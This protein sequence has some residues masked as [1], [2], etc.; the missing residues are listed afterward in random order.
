MSL[1]EN[2]FTV[3]PKA[4]IRPNKIVF[5]NQILK[6]N[7]PTIK[8]KINIASDVKKDLQAM[9]VPV[10]IMPT[11][12]VHSFDLSI[13]AKA[14]I[15]QKV[16]WLYSLAKTNSV[17]NQNGKTLH[18]FKMN[19]IT[20]TLPAIQEHETSVITG[21]CLNQFL[22]E[23]KTRFNLQNYVWR[24]EFQKNGNAH[25]HIATDCYMDYHKARTIW[26]RCLGKLG[27][28]EKYAAQF[29]GM[30]LQQ[31]SDKFN[32][33]RDIE[34]NVLKSRFTYGQASRWQNPNTVDVKSVGNAKQIA[35][36]ISKYITKD[37]DIKNNKIVSDREPAS[38][39]LRLWFCSRS[40]SRL[41]KIEYFLE[42]V[43]EL[44]DKALAG[45]QAV[46]QYFY[47]YVKV[48][49]FELKEQTFET[50]ASLWLLYNNYAR[51][52]GYVAWRPL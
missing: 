37:S 14:R 4:S 25:Y 3:I 38:T 23:C 17:K 8:E 52:Q 30:T 2:P 47:D 19:F 9:G 6:R 27:Y 43:N 11:N 33:N 12:T 22:T 21:D 35:F 20:L 46:K 34:F 51:G 49:Y 15:R 28:I 40:L 36:Y 5:Y 13:K 16:T 18:A 45:L 39:N 32:K 50:K 42:T 10:H 48:W 24:L 7:A 26:N 41:D 31:Y 29:K 1:Q 44:A